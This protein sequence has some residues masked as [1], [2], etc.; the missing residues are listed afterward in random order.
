ME[1]SVVFGASVT[2]PAA[3]A[4]AAAAASASATLLCISSMRFWTIFG[5]NCT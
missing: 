1:N 3:A 2:D 4:A 5:I